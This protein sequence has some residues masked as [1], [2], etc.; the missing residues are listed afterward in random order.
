[1][2]TAAVAIWGDGCEGEVADWARGVLN[3]GPRAG[4]GEL[5]VWGVA[6][7]LIPFREGLLES[8]DGDDWEA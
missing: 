8:D 4:W 7:A 6:G 5:W 3:A 1:M 2:V